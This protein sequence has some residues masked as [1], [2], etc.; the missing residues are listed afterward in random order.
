M[1]SVMDF[2]NNAMNAK[3]MCFEVNR[4]RSTTVMS[5]TKNLEILTDR[6][7]SL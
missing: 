6:L 7:I 5:A 1:L 4:V 3:V 2:Q